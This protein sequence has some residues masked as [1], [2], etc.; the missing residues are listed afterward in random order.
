MVICA[1]RIS[2]VS[3]SSDEEKILIASG[4]NKITPI[5]SPTHHVSHV[6]PMF[7]NGTMSARSNVVAPELAATKQL[8]GATSK[9]KFNID[10]GE[11]G[12]IPGKNLRHKT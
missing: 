2:F 5:T 9:R 7:G 11:S 3:C 4:V 8:I 6:K 10:L 1:L 12:I